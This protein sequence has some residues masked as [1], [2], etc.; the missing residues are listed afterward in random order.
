MTDTVPSR[1]RGRR[2]APLRVRSAGAGT[3]LGD[4]HPAPAAASRPWTLRPPPAGIALHP[5]TGVTPR[6]LA[7]FALLAGGASCVAEFAGALLGIDLRAWAA[8]FA[9]GALIVYVPGGVDALLLRVRRLHDVADGTP[10]SAAR[11]ISSGVEARPL[12]RALVVVAC[13]T[14][15]AFFGR[16]VFVTRGGP[17][18]AADPAALR[19]MALA[20]AFVVLA[21]WPWTGRGRVVVH[22]Q[23]DGLRRGGTVELD[24]SV[25][26]GAQTIERVRAVLRCVRERRAGTFAPFRRPEVVWSRE[27]RLDP[28]A[29]LVP[30][31]DLRV[32]FRVP[33]GLPPADPGPGAREPVHWELVLAGTAGGDTY[34]DALPLPVA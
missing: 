22:W 14:V 27:V 16:L 11:P 25:A 13:V 15:L 10:R 6:R 26:P 17:P 29:S 24:V 34:A 4:M 32:A 5:R 21:A 23:A 9:V 18:P 3:T 30:G 33:G 20:I 7:T 8:V 19:A 2:D 12:G 1:R 28:L 31:S